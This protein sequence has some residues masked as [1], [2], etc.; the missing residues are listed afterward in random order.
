MCGSRE[1]CHMGS[2]FDN[3]FLVDTN[4]TKSGPSPPRQRNAISLESRWCP[5]IECWLGS[6]VIFQGI[7]TS[8]AKKPYSFVI[9]LPPLDPH[10]SVKL[11]GLDADKSADMDLNCLQNL[12]SA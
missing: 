3:F 8:M 10:M 6:L 1:F 2:N 4:T 5:N 12:G 7:Q 11:Q 9:L